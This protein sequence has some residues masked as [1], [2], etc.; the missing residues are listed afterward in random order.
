MIYSYIINRKTLFPVRF[1]KIVVAKQRVSVVPSCFLE[2]K[3]AKM[4]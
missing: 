2:K 3:F 1:K 4:L